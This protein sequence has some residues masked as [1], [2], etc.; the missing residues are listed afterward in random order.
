MLVRN[1]GHR[2][3]GRPMV[4]PAMQ[5][6]VYGGFHKGEVQVTLF[7]CLPFVPLPPLVVGR[8]RETYE[9]FP[10]GSLHT[11]SPVRKYDLEIATSGIRPPRNDV[12]KSVD[13]R[14]RVSLQLFA[15]PRPTVKT[16]RMHCRG[17]RPR[18]PAFGTPRGR[19]LQFLSKGIAANAAIPV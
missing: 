14:G 6:K 12:E 8:V 15:S 2:K 11:F 1:V 18:R 10:G 19:P 13:T 16:K 7:A 17:R 5:T 3:N 4:A 9:T